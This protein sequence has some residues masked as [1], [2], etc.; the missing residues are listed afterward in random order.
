MKKRFKRHKVYQ[1]TGLPGKY[2]MIR[3][4]GKYLQDF[5]FKIGDVINITTSQNAIVIKKQK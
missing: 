3:I 5:G 4:G 2:P 1:Q